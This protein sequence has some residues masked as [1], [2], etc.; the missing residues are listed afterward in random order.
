MSTVDEIH[1]YSNW[2]EEMNELT[3]FHRG[4]FTIRVGK[5]TSLRWSLLQVGIEVA[6]TTR[7]ENP[8]SMVKFIEK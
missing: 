5:Y 3:S 2:F 6:K 4:R 8:S 1:L 7:R